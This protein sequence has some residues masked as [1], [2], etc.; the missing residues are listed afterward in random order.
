M[1][2]CQYALVALVLVCIVFAA[3]PY[4]LIAYRPRGDGNDE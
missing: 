2:L 3:F 1:T 4:C